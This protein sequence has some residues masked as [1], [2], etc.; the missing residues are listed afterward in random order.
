MCLRKPI[1]KTSLQSSVLVCVCGPVSHYI[2]ILQWPF[3]PCNLSLKLVAPGLVQYVH[4][5]VESCELFPLQRQMD[6]QGDL[7][8]SCKSTWLSSSC[9]AYCIALMLMILLMLI[10]KLKKPHYQ[11]KQ[12][13]EVLTILVCQCEQNITCL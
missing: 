10:P 2:D 13:A 7:D 12:Y 8:R 11:E 4:Q 3:T 9:M 1:W 6:R 5:N